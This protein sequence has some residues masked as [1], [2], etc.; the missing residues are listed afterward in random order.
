M[1]DTHQQPCI[2]LCTVDNVPQ[3]SFCMMDSPHKKEM[4]KKIGP[5]CDE[6]MVPWNEFCEKITHVVANAPLFSG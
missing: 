1:C 5:A 4:F 6:L 2:L 3:C